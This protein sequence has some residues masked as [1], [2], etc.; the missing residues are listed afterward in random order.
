MGDVY[1]ARDTALG[2]MVALKIIPPEMAFSEDR[3]VRFKREAQAVAALN[4]P[5][6]V[7]VFSVEE[8]EGIH[9]ITMELVRGKTLTELLAKTGLELSHFLDLALALTDVVSAAH[10][11]GII[12]RDL[13]PDNLME[14][15]D[16]GSR[17]WTSVW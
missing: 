4:H 1:A 7:T 2:R 12:H 13:K 5:N 10:R 15:E 16:G 3:R 9:F 8:D 14:D 11:K 17:S 6:I